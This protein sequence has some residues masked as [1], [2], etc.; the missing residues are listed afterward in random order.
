[1]IKPR[2]TSVVILITLAELAWLAAFGLLFAYRGKV[3][4]LGRVRHDLT[5]TSNQLAQWEQKLPD[6]AALLKQ[7]KAANEETAQLRAG[8]QIFKN[9]LA[10]ASP[11]EFARRMASVAGLEQRLAEAEQTTANL[12][13]TLAEKEQSLAGYQ[14]TQDE[15]ARLRKR[16][17]TLPPNVDTLAELYR[18]ATNRMTQLETQTRQAQA[19]KLQVLAEVKHREIG[20]F[21]VR[22]ELTGL[23]SGNLRRVV[24]VV[25]TSSS[26]RNSPSWKSAKDLVRTWI[27]FL[28]VEECAMVNF[29]DIAI[30]YPKSGYLRVRQSD[31]TGIRE[32][33]DEL[34]NVFD[35]V[36]T[37]T[38]TDLLRGLHLAYQYPQ[39]DVI[40]VFT[41]G[42]PHVST[43]TDTAFAKAILT[44]VEGH[45]G[46]PI[47][48]VA[49]GNY[50]TEGAGGPWPKIN[51]SIAF[52]KELAHK[53]GGNFLGR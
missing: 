40:V 52:L 24:F 17:S 10:G 16:I 49:L 6:T 23:P 3:G 9:Q 48:T 5:S 53:S 43:H 51:A 1:M 12:K 46:I 14:K 29:N 22:R 41:D 25:D 11:E 33:R 2:K 13:H 39:P 50:E 44:E 37:G 15:L 21:S 35:Q 45:P 27:E 26:M 7:L 8:L 36:K 28:P 42:H 32:H 4:E 34:L 19:D 20:E 38:F 30:G 18:N 31:G 47:L